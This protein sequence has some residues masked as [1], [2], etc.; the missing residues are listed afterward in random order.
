MVV[1]IDTIAALMARLCVVHAEFSF[2]S[3]TLQAS[4]FRGATRTPRAFELPRIGS[5]PRRRTACS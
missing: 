3:T 2:Q 5:P 4:Y 1:D